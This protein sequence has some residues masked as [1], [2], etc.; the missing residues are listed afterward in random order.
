MRGK[1]VGLG[2]LIGFGATVLT[3]RVMGSML[4]QTSAHDPLTFGLTILLLGCGRTCRLSPAGATCHPRE[5]DRSA[6]NGMTPN[7]FR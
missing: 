3:S 4:F 2:L 7:K 1:L 5:S 6:A